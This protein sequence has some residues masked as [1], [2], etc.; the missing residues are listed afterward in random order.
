MGTFSN[1]LHLRL[2]DTE[3][4]MRAYATM[5]RRG[6]YRLRTA[7][8]IPHYLETF[9]EPI[10]RRVLV[11]GAMNGWITV[12]D[13]RFDAQHLRLLDRVAGRVTFALQCA[14]VAF[15]L[16]DGD[17]LYL[18]QWDRGQCVNRWCSWPGW[19][20]DG[21]ASDAVREKWKGEPRTLLPLCRADVT[22]ADVAALMRDYS[23]VGAEHTTW[24]EHILNRLHGLLGIDDG[25]RTYA[26]LYAHPRELY[27][28]RPDGAPLRID[29]DEAPDPYWYRF[30]HLHFMR[31]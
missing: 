22:V 16:H 6:G 27:L 20:G 26:Q 2:D 10:F 24:A 28:A 31:R 12:I 15:F 5:L 13:Q 23:T 1:T 8:G 29:R 21:E 19:F 25:A 7:A 14:A 30:V 9:D 11:S 18:L 17:V 4:V 3:I